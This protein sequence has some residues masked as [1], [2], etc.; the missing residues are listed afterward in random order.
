M[1]EGDTIYRAA[2]TLNRALSGQT[3]ERFETVLAQLAR[4]DTDTPLR[5]RTID[6]V[7]ASGKHLLI[8]FSGDLVLRTHMRMNGSWHIYR[9]GERWRRRRADMR[10]ALFTKDWVAVGF[11]IPVAELHDARSLARQADIRGQGPDVLGPE[12]NVSEVIQRVRLRPEATVAEVLLNQRIAAGIGNVY[13][14]ETLFLCGIDPFST[15]GALED[16]D[17]AALYATARKLM[18]ANVVDG[19][20]AAIVTYA[21]HRRTTHRSGDGEGLWVYGRRG[22][23]CRKCG[24]PIEYAKRGLDA[25]STYWCPSCQPG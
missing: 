8:R 4:V 24:A 6:E 9:P 1:P 2:C 22:E 23:A 5:G 7:S 16:D 12:F 18:K 13:K 10:V 20:S 21:G 17:I 19:T 14:S 3:V 11:N 15:S 25:R